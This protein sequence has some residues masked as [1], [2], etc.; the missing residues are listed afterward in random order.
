MIKTE[1]QSRKLN[2]DLFFQYLLGIKKN[3]E[4]AE[5]ETWETYH[6]GSFRDV[7]DYIKY[8]RASAR[9][10]IISQVLRVYSE[11]VIGAGTS[12]ADVVEVVRCKKCKYHYLCAIEHEVKFDETFFCKWGEKHE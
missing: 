7:D 12:I 9:L 4:K 10:D 8:T 11:K 5:A 6:E 2:E 3:A 1:A